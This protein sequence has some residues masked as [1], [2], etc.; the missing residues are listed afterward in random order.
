[1]Y[2]LDADIFSFTLRSSLHPLVIRNLDAT[3]P[4]ERW[5]SIIGVQEILAW[6][7]N[8]LLKTASQQSPKVLRAYGEFHDLLR[9]LCS[10]Q[11]KPF[12]EAAMSEFSNMA[13]AGNIGIMDRRVA[14]IALAN[15]FTV[16]TNNEQHFL[17]IKVVRPE[18][19][20]ENWNK[21]LYPRNP[22]N[23]I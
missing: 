8:P 22:T 6:K 1:M 12:D 17:P 13:G 9:V 23:T 15:K 18:L 20:I 11:I 7:Y 3:Q 5:L 21:R 10:I 2:L 14:A 4:S 19:Q 16:V